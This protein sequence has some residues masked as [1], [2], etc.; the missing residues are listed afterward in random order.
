METVLKAIIL[1]LVVFMG[2]LIGNAQRFHCCEKGE[3]CDLPPCCRGREKR[4][5]AHPPCCEWNKKM[6]P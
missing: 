4:G 6:K 5:C 2:G 3:F 1:F